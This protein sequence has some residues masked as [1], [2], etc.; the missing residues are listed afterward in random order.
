[1]S[2]VCTS[3]TAKWEGDRL[4]HIG[5]ICD[6]ILQMGNLTQRLWKLLAAVSICLFVFL[7]FFL[8]LFHQSNQDSVRCK[9]IFPIKAIRIQSCVSLC[10]LIFPSKAIGFHP[11]KQSGFIP[12]SKYM[13]VPFF[14]IKVFRIHPSKLSGFGPHCKY[15]FPNLSHHFIRIQSAVNIYF[16]IFPIKAVRI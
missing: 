8:S 14:P 13:F 2:T 7:S 10:F 15:P 16:A 11:T 6:T 5:Y 1:M 9:Y 12:R 4:W 3:Q